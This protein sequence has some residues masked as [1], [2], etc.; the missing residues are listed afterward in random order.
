MQAIILAGGNG[1][2]L[3]PLT[4]VFPKPLIPIGDM[5]ILEIVLRQL[6]HYGI[7]RVTLAVNHLAPLIE[8][9]FGNGTKLGLAID[10]SLEDSILGTAGPLRLISQLDSDFILM[11]GDLLTTLQYQ[12][13]YQFHLDQGGIATIATFQKEVKIDLGVL[14]SRGL[15]LTDYIEKPTYR[16]QVSMGIYVLNHRALAYIPKEQ[17][18][19]MPELMLALMDA[20]ER[21]VCYSGDYDWMDIGRM[22]DYD[23]AMAIFDERKNIYLPS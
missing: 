22:E 11:N 17:K 15:A 2:R 20:G 4:N 8:A 9:F 12:D 14:E 16:F 5:P 1:T 7:D 13:L 21:V 3:K 23:K 18:F 19:D 6:K 10:Y